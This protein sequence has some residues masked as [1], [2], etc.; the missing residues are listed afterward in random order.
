MLREA[1]SRSRVSGHRQTPLTSPTRSPTCDGREVVVAGGDGSLH[2]VVAALHER[3]ELADAA[4][5]LIPLG[6]GNDFARGVGLP[7]DPAEAAAGA[8][9]RPSA[10]GS[11]CSSTTTDGDRGQRRACR[12]RR[13]GRPGGASRGSRRLGKLGYA[14]G[15]LHRRR[16]DRRATGCASW[17][18]T[19]SCRRRATAGCSRSAS[20]TAPTSAAAHP[21]TPTPTRA[22]AR[23]DVVVSFAVSPLGPAAVRH[24]AEARHPRRARRRPD[25]RAPPRSAV[26]GPGSGATPTASSPAR[27][28]SRTLAG[29]AGRADDAAARSRDSRAS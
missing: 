6:T 16:Q 28:R 14:V 8:R 27:T 19:R 3:G 24:P 11:T 23:S 12:R 18:T 2:A 1:G 10:A 13:R 22:T 26:S 5:G 15:A 7:L 20:A 25:G 9:R 17:P 29:A 4:V 21:L